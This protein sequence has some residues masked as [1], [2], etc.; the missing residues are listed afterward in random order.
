MITG[1]EPVFPNNVVDLLAMR[2]SM[3]D[4]D[5]FVARRPLRAEDLEQSIGVFGSMWV[6]DPESYEIRGLGEGSSVPGPTEPTVARYVVGIQA[7]IKDLDEERGLAKHSILSTTIRGILYRDTPLRVAL[8]QLS[9]QLNGV[10]E[11]TLKW[12]VTAQRFLSNEIG[13]NEWLFLSTVEFWLDTE[14][15]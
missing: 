5:L 15:Y 11:R 4:D 1:N 8:S 6:P 13:D 2:F 3:I 14:I 12:G 9:V 7:F 10:G